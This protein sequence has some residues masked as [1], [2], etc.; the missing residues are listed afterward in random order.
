MQ[1]G[2]V[3]GAGGGGHEPAAAG[4]REGVEEGEEEKLRRRLRLRPEH[5]PTLLALAAHLARAHPM[6]ARVEEA[7]AL[8][9]RALPL[10]TSPAS[11]MYILTTTANLLFA[12]GRVVEAEGRYREALELSAGDVSACYNYALL[13]D[14]QTPRRDREAERLYKRVL[15]TDPAHMPTLVNYAVLL[16]QV[17]GE[18]SAAE[19][20]Y[21]CLLKAA[22]KA[23]S[24]QLSFIQASPA[25]RSSP[26]RV[27]GE[28]AETRQEEAGAAARGAAG[29]AAGGG[30][31]AG[32]GAAA[33]A[34]VAGLVNYGKLL[35]EERGDVV[36]AQE[37]L[38]EAL[39]VS[40]AHVAARVLLGE[41]L[42]AQGEAVEAERQLR[43]ALRLRPQDPWAA[44]SLAAL[45][46]SEYQDY[47]AAGKLYA[48]AIREAAKGRGGGGADVEAEVMLRC[49]YAGLLATATDDF[50]Q[51][52]QLLHEAMA[53]N[54]RIKGAARFAALLEQKQLA[55]AACGAERLACESGGEEGLVLAGGG[56]VGGPALSAGSAAVSGGVPL[57]CVV[58]VRVMGGVTWRSF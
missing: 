5:L 4:E 46:E 23:G 49:R 19:D 34:V 14:S 17:R 18:V 33:S 48:A 57:V 15:K 52:E 28:A 32:V 6:P 42:A 12:R 47:D 1:G 22:V 29:G 24:I 54:P 38:N 45:L 35:L 26:P 39:R 43:S 7:I 3:G 27:Q 58:E 13:L 53:L 21:L 37:C 20:L 50:A 25:G 30:A 8:Y 41:T 16:Q 9:E 40:P 56:V 44:A 36:S 51:A 2:S 31:G 11:Q 10:A 55:A